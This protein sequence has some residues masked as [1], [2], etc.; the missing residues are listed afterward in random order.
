MAFSTEEV[1]CVNNPKRKA[2]QVILLTLSIE[3]NLGS[4]AFLVANLADEDPT[5]PVMIASTGCVFCLET[6]DVTTAIAKAFGVVSRGKIVKGD[7]T[8]TACC[9]GRAGKLKDP[10]GN[11]WMT[12]SPIGVIAEETKLLFSAFVLLSMKFQ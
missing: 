12:C 4:F 10:F 7:A 11:V 6:D 2:E 8:T 9:G 1:T 5:A 3:L